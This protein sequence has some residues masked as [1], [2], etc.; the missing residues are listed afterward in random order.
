MGHCGSSTLWDRAHELALDIYRATER[1]PSEQR[2]VL[3]NTMRCAAVA[4]TA[5]AADCEQRDQTHDCAAPL[6][7][8]T[9]LLAQ[10]VYHIELARELGCL[11]GIEAGWLQDAAEALAQ[12]VLDWR[13]EGKE[14][15]HAVAQ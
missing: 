1:F 4:I 13:A 10:V 2:Y 8:M 7:Q 6:S 15:G 3:V 12:I 9:R 11:S 14:A 5:A